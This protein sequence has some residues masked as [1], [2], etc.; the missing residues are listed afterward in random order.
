MSD[1]TAPEW[2]PLPKIEDLFEAALAG[3]KF[4]NINAPTA[5][6][7]FERDLP[8]GD[9]PF[10]LYSLAT[11]NG[12]KVSILLEELGIDYDAHTI[13]IMSGDQFSSGFVAVN[14]NSKIPAAVDK[15]GPNGETMNLFE[16]GS[17]VLYL[18]E[19]YNRFYP[20]DVK[21]RAEVMN[22]MFWQV[23]AEFNDIGLGLVLS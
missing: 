4:A 3:N 17:I 1:F 19:K 23:C 6:A 20:T 7:K 11:P 5:G 18:A 14:P 13:N 2:T 12:Q 9:A 15:E 16:S 10:Q 21:L 22:W 8:A